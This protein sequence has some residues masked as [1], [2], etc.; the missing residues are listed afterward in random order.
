M[1]LAEAPIAEERQKPLGQLALELPFRSAISS[2]TGLSENRNKG[3]CCAAE[4]ERPESFQIQATGVLTN[5]CWWFAVDISTNMEL[6]FKQ[7]HLQTVCGRASRESRLAATYT[8]RSLVPWPAQARRAALHRPCARNPDDAGVNSSAPPRP[9]QP[10]DSLPKLADFSRGVPD[11]L[12]ADE[13]TETAR[14][15]FWGK[16]AVLVLGV[17]YWRTS[18]PALQCLVLQC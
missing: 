7:V 11:L 14:E 18:S 10:K 5:A 16:I 3:F 4:L 15:K 1:R 9:A 6:A 12:S 17:S 2:S 13:E 8:D